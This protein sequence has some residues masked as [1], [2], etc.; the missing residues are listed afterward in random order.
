MKRILLITTGGTISCKPGP[1]GLAPALS[2]SDL[3][4]SVD[5]HGC[6]I[7]CVFFSEID[8][9]D[10]CPAD[11]ERLA[12]L[13][14][15]NYSLHDGFVITHGTDTLA[16]TAA[17]LSWMIDGPKPIVLT[18]SQ[19][20]V[21]EAGSDAPDN[22]RMALLAACE[23]AGGVF[24]AFCGRLI[25]G[26]C[27]KKTA[28]FD[29]DAFISVNRP[30]CAHMQNGSIVWRN[31]PGG[32][33]QAEF[34]CTLNH[35]VALVKLH[36][37]INPDSIEYAGEKNDA[38]VLECYGIG[39]LPL[40]L[41][42]AVKAVAAA[43]KPVVIVSQSLSGGTGMKGYASGQRGLAISGMLEGGTLTA[44]AAVTGLMCA[45]AKTKN[46][47]EITRALF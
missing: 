41:L 38:L 11:W 31:K 9:V 27:A 28:S 19:R 25:D 40:S 22:L 30:D 8:S 42:D 13:L 3:L 7:D 21:G 17:A 18:G 39:A 12:A 1:N 15:D 32:A 36:P 43:G 23:N 33:R 29:T 47:D 4:R 45:L 34:T 44:E 5:V 24:V 14:R 16:W 26:R 20:P 35:R 46:M 2:P 37:A 10:I 6:E